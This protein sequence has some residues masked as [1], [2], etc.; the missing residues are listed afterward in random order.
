MGKMETEKP[1]A[2]SQVWKPQFREDCERH[3]KQAAFHTLGDSVLKLL[4]ESGL[5]PTVK[6]V[7]QGVR[8]DKPN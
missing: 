8:D 4:W 1:A 2:E 3:G 7:V 6:E 5:E